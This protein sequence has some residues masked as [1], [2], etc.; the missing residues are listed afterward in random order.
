M[1]DNGLVGGVLYAIELI[2]VYSG[3]EE[4]VFKTG[5]VFFVID[6]MADGVR[7][8]DVILLASERHGGWE[9]GI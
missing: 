9:W 8:E 1:V 2:G 5:N 7:V 6:M 3:G 4:A